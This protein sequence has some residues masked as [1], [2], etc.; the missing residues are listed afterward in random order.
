MGREFAKELL[1]LPKTVEDASK[2]SVEKLS[3]KID[4]VC[5]G[6]VVLLGVGG[7]FS[8][9]EFARKLFDE[10]G[11]SS[12]SMTTLE[13]LQSKQN[14]SKF[15]VFIFTAGGN[16]KDILS[17]FKVA[18]EREVKQIVVVCASTHSK[19]GEIAVECETAFVFAFEVEAGRDGYLATNSLVAM[20]TL[21]ARAFGEPQLH[22]DEVQAWIQTGRDA[23]KK[24]GAHRDHFVILHSGWATLA[25]VDLESKLSEAG[26]FSSMLVDYRHFAHGRHN[27]I[28]KQS[29]KTA[30]VAFI[31]EENAKLADAT[32][33]KLPAKPMPWKCRSQKPGPVGAIQL[34]LA[35]FGFTA[36]A[37]ENARIDPGRPGVPKYGSLL[38][39]LGP[40][41]I[42]GKRRDPGQSFDIQ[43][44]ID[45]KLNAGGYAG[46][47]RSLLQSHATKFASKIHNAQF[48]ALVTD[49]DGTVLPL[50]TRNG[51]I[52]K[53]TQ[54][55]MLILL[56]RRIPIYFAT[57]RGDS[58]QSGLKEAFPSSF[59]RS[60][61]IGYY[62]GALCL[63]LTETPDFNAGNTTISLLNEV[64]TIIDRSP[65]L[66]EH[67]Q[68][69]NKLWQLSIFPKECVPSDWVVNCL[70]DVVY[71]SFGRSLRIVTSS[72]SIDILP[73][74]VS[75]VNCRTLASN[76]I[77]KGLDVLAFGDCGAH[78][79]NDY[80]L[81]QGPFSLSVNSVSSNLDSCWN[82][83]PAGTS[84]ALGLQYYLKHFKI[85]DEHFI[86]AK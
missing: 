20:C 4:S 59:W 7:S 67:V 1:L 77:R 2:I 69:K 38:Y 50:N 11:I 34:L 68:V 74:E 18:R 42:L 66:K 80:E 16:N 29:D 23:Y 58:I 54:E 82:L 70:L 83:L 63:P 27:W 28:D 84:H 36:A 62:N 73:N 37:G 31:T 45:R 49:Y 60:I 22:K 78:P 72:H 24:M 61:Y 57:G 52:P 51:P 33:K 86:V 48:G 44:G 85:A 71:N 9:A 75:K 14:F 5:G 19:I 65:A 79:G 8:T 40:V 3:H 21:L 10:R 81:L 6:P 32:V 55:I 64:Q 76:M 41:G 39:S 30:V 26:L 56:K 15:S 25:G 17:A 47:S 12:Q 13:F 53:F 46:Q 43:R 35:A